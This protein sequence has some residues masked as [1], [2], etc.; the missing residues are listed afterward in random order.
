MQR[1]SISKKER[2]DIFERDNFTCQYCGEK[3]PQI[4]LVIDHIY[5]VSKGGKNDKDNLITSCFNCNS[6]K[7][8][9]IIKKTPQKIKENLKNL[10]E[11]K[12]Q[13]EAFY[14][15]QTKIDNL[16]EKKVEQLSEVWNDCWGGKYS[17]NPRGK[18]TIR[19]FLK[20]LSFS[21]IEESIY[22][23]TSKISK[24]EDCFKYLCGILHNK[25]K[26]YGK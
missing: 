10:E 11:K 7:S 19:T 8:D 6:G 9:S 20:F 16:I 12:I 18:S 25:K 13:L 26:N 17:F 24:V 3:P 2:F 1:I 5:P 21:E 23:A 22:I 15:Y 4:V 14:K